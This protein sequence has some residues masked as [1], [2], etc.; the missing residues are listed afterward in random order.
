MADTVGAVSLQPGRQL[1]GGAM[2]F[3]GNSLTMTAAFRLRGFE[4]A[5]GRAA[6]FDHALEYS[7]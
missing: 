4:H 1:A 6:R 5:N 7:F 2:A 3:D